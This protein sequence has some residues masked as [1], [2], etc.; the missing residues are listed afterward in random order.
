ME[1]HEF[2]IFKLEHWE[3]TGPGDIVVRWVWAEHVPH[4]QV[5]VLYWATGTTK[6]GLDL[7]LPLTAL[8]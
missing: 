6:T 4:I 8:W 7:R 3:E 1:E 5:G 2:C